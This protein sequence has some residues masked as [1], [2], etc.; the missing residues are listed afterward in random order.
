MAAPTQSTRPGRSRRAQPPALPPLPLAHARLHRALRGLLLTAAFAVPLLLTRN[1]MSAFAVP[2]SLLFWLLG[3]LVALTALAGLAITRR[4]TLARPAVS[5]ALAVF[6]LGLLVGTAVSGAPLRA[7]FGSYDRQ[8]GLLSYAMGMVLLV[9]AA[10]ALRQRDPNEDVAFHPAASLLRTIIA[11]TAMVSGYGA[12]QG[13]GWDPLGWTAS[14]VGSPIISTMGNRNF[15]AGYLAIGAVCALWGMV[16]T[17]WPDGYRVAC[18]M[19]AFVT[20]LVVLATTSAQGPIALAVGIIAFAVVVVTGKPAARAW[21]HAR[22]LPLLLAGLLGVGLVVF[23]SGEGRPLAGVRA[24]VEASAWDRFT[25]AQT[26]Y[27]IGA[28]RPLTGQGLELFLDHYHEN[29]PL[30]R[31]LR[32]NIQPAGDNAHDVPMQLFAGG[33]LLALLGWLGWVA[34]VGLVLLA[35]LRSLTGERR[36]LLGALGA[37][38]VAYLMQSLVSIDIAPLLMTGWLLSGAILAVAPPGRTWSRP[39]PLAAAL[40]AAVLAVPLLIAGLI[41]LSF[42]LR[43]E[44]A[45][46]VAARGADPVEAEIAA[47]RTLELAPWDP[48]YPLR[49]ARRAREVG[50]SA[51]SADL[52]AEAI[53][54]DPRYTLAYY[55]GAQALIDVSRIDEA[56]AYWERVIELAPTTTAMLD[57]AATFFAAIGRQDRA[58]EIA[59]YAAWVRANAGS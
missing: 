40:G 45:G 7:L 4:V 16:T 55:E 1:M 15:V 57:E 31:S 17:T 12:I 20:A 52:Y 9:A 10:A 24:G 44:L 53:A 6:S 13:L 36:L 49:I 47:Q 51:L 37:A 54:R 28:E 8:A 38:W 30:S 29:R 26:G 23:L 19:L 14:V 59:G 2:K 18:G 3:G 41:G 50:N 21:F 22:A 43:A 5:G 32:Q 34:T 39:V 27:A 33:G 35:G 42:P 48:R 25:L 46:A 58:E 56:A 11:A